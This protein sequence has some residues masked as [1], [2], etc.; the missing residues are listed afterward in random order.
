MVCTGR[1]DAALFKPNQYK[2]ISYESLV[3][4]PRDQCEQL[5]EFLEV[6]Y[7]S[8]MDNYYE[9]RTVENAGLSTNAAWLPP[10]PGRRKWQEQMK[11]EESERFE[12]AAGD[13][14]TTLGYE[15]MFHEIRESVYQQVAELKQQ[16]ASEIGSRWQLPESW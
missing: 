2:E 1:R 16:F 4:S 14:L 3:H 11:P 15:R 9:G 5:A 6:P 7:D 13:L 12:A 10:T 8:A